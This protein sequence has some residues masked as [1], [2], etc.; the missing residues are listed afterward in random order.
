[1][2]QR[3]NARALAHISPYF[4]S[5]RG[6]GVGDGEDRA[7]PDEDQPGASGA[8]LAG[9]RFACV[10]AA[11]WVTKEGRC[12]TDALVAAGAATYADPAYVPPVFPNYPITA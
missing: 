1:V 5:F 4:G 11:F 8:D 3:I 12:Q 7:C 10:A 9:A 6:G 2:H